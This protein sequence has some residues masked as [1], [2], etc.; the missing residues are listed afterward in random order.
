MSPTAKG[1]KAD[2]SQCA[3]TF[4]MSLIAKGGKA[5][6]RRCAGTFYMRQKHA[7]HM[8]RKRN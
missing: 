1:G 2:E 8:K 6:E 4:Y 7:Q 5:D 3:G